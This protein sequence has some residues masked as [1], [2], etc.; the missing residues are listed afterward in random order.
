VAVLLLLGTLACSAESDA[1]TAFRGNR[2]GEQAFA[3]GLARRALDAYCLRRERISVPA[4]L[5][6]GLRLRS[7]VFVSAM[8]GDAPR[9]CM[10]ALHPTRATLAEEIIEAACAAAARDWRFAPLKPEE[11]P[12][13]RVIVSVLA[14]PECITDPWALDPV[15]EGLAVRSAK[16]TGVVL[17]GESPRRQRMV[18]WARVRAGAKPGERVEFFRIRAVRVME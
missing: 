15:T 5:P 17:P 16:T 3:L 6:P 11:L 2:H 13:L 9:C 18:T 4:D 7:A 12:K 14:P 10:G 1:L 8:L